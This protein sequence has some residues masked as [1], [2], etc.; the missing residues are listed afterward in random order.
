MSG[1][2]LGSAGYLTERSHSTGSTHP[3][4]VFPKKSSLL[5]RPAT[6]TMRGFLATDLV[7][8]NH[9]QV[10]RTTPELAPALLTTSPHP[11]EDV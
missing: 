11:R 3:S 10:T 2:P 4:L 6:Q 5:S 9:D 8:R 1:G 7:I